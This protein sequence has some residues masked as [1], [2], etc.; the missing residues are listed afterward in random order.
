MVILMDKSKTVPLRQAFEKWMK[1]LGEEYMLTKHDHPSLWGGSADAVE[2]WEA[3]PYSHP[4]TVGAYE[5]WKFCYPYMG[6]PRG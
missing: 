1:N 2:I 6:G 4:W 5:A 3:N